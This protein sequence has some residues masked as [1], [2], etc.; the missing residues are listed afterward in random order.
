M[1]NVKTVF[2]I[3]T[4]GHINSKKKI[5]N[6]SQ[7]VTINKIGQEAAIAVDKEHKGKKTSK[8]LKGFMIN[9]EFVPVD[10]SSHWDKTIIQ[11][12]GKLII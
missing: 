1:S 9:D 8:V 12:D 6:S 4:H 7:L 10:L 5:T 11:K 2:E 3:K